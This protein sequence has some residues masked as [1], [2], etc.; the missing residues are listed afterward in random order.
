MGANV[1]RQQAPLRDVQLVSPQV[2]AMPGDI[3]L[4]PATAWS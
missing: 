1:H 2:S 3:W 4:R